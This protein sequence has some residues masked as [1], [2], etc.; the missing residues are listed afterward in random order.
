MCSDSSRA[1]I[2]NSRPQRNA[3][4]RDIPARLGSNVLDA[5]PE[6]LEDAMEVDVPAKPLRDGTTWSC[7]WMKSCQYRPGR[8]CGAVNL[9]LMPIP[10]PHARAEGCS[11]HANLV[12]RSPDHLVC[13]DV[14]QQFAKPLSPLHTGNLTVLLQEQLQPGSG[15]PNR[16]AH[17]VAE[18]LFRYRPRR[19]V[20]RSRNALRC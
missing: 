6:P 2:P 17:P 14:P 7:S 3:I 13:V 11:H 10:L 5:L 16:S 12:L 1:I 4:R 18:T 15:V 8:P 19:I 20:C 9:L